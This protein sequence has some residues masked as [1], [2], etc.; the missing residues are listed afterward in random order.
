MMA[1]INEEDAAELSNLLEESLQVIASQEW[2][3]VGKLN[4]SLSDMLF[5]L[6]D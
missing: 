6:E 4:E 3:T 1:G 2:E 5:Y